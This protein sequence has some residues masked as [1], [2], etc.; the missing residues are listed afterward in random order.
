MLEKDINNY[1]TK[2]K[3]NCTLLS[4]LPK[5]ITRY[6]TLKKL[7]KSFETNKNLKNLKNN[8]TQVQNKFLLFLG[9]AKKSRNLLLGFET[10]KNNFKN[11]NKKNLLILITQDISENSLEKIIF[12]ANK[13]QVNIQKINYTKD[14]IYDYLGKYSGIISITDQNFVNKI[15]ILIQEELHDSQIQSS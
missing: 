3:P 8:K 12:E 4:N 15:K 6:S 5:D 13:Y 1:E 9:L 14:Q 2:E 11:K 7:N 10:V